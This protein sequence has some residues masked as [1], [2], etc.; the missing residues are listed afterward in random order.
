MKKQCN[1]IL[2]LLLT[3]V[4]LLTVLPISAIAS[5]WLEVEGETNK[6]GN[7]TVSDITVTLDAKAL[8]QYL[9]DRDLSG[10]VAGI[11]IDGV[12]NIVSADELFAI[13]PVEDFRA[14]IDAIESDIDPQDYLQ[15]IDVDA[16][17]KTVD[18]DKLAELMLNLSEPESYVSDFDALAAHIDLVRFETALDYVD[19]EKLERD[20]PNDLQALFG[21]TS[22]YAE[23][24]MQAGGLQALIATINANPDNADKQMS[25]AHILDTYIKSGKFVDMI[26]ALDPAGILHAILADGTFNDVFS[27]VSLVRDIGLSELVKLVDLKPFLT[28][29]Y[30]SGALKELAKEVATS[31]TPSKYV[32][33]MNQILN[34][35]HENVEEIKINGV[36][37]T[38]K[39]NGVLK[40]NIERLLE[41]LQTAI[42]TLEELAALNSKVLI[43]NVS[44]SITYCSDATGNVAKTKTINAKLALNGGIDE[45]RAVA[46]KLQSLLGKFVT[47]N[48]NG[49]DITVQ[50]VLPAKFATAIRVV[51]EELGE[52][53]TNTDLLALRDELLQLYDAN[54]SDTANFVTNLTLDQIVALLEKIDSEKFEKAYN[55]VMRQQYVQIA[56]DYIESYT[57]K[58][59]SSVELDDIIRKMDDLP[60][61]PT[62]EQIARKVESITGYDLVSKLPQR[63][64]GAWGRV[65]GDRI[66]DIFSKLAA[67]AGVDVDIQQILENA[68]AAADPVQ[69]LYDTFTNAVE[70]SGSV[71]SAAQK[72]LGNLADLL[73]SSGVGSR[74]DSIHLDDLYQGEG[75]FGGKRTIT[76]NP[77]ALVERLINKAVN[78]LDSRTD[79]DLSMLDRV[80]TAVLSMISDADMS[81]TIDATIKVTGLYQASFHD[82]NGDLIDQY[83]LPAGIDLKDLIDYTPVDP[84]KQFN[85]WKANNATYTTMPKADMVFYPDLGDNTVVVSVYSPDAISSIDIPV[86]S[87]ILLSGASLADKAD[88]LLALVKSTD[89]DWHE[90]CTVV[91]Y[92][93]ENGQ[94]V[95]VWDL[96]TPITADMSLTWEIIPVTYTVTVVDPDTMQIVGTL[97]VN[98]GALLS[99][100]DLN[101]IIA[102]IVDKDVSW[103]LVD[104]NGSIADTAYDFTAPVKAALTLTW[105]ILPDTYT[106]TVVNPL[107]VTDVKGS[108]TVIRGETVQSILSDMDAL[109]NA[110]GTK[111]PAW[112]TVENGAWGQSSKYELDAAVNADLTLTWKYYNV[113]IFNYQDTD[114]DA[115]VTF[116]ELGRDETLDRDFL[117]AQAGIP[118]GKTPAWYNVTI[119]G[120]GLCVFGADDK[121]ASSAFGATVDWDLSLTWKYYTVSVYQNGRLDEAVLEL[122]DGDILTAEM[123]DAIYV[124]AGEKA[125]DWYA[126]DAADGYLLNKANRYTFGSA[127]DWDI[128][129]APKYYTV[130]IYNN[131]TD[132]QA[133]DTF[134]LGRGETMQSFLDTL[135][136][137][138]GAD[139]ASGM[140]PAWYEYAAGNRTTLYDL[141][142]TVVWDLD[143]TWHY[144]VVT[145]EIW[146]STGDGNYTHYTELADDGHTYVVGYQSLISALLGQISG[147]YEIY[148]DYLLTQEGTEW[149]GILYQKFHNVWKDTAGTQLDVT[150][151]ILDDLTI[152]VYIEPDQT[153]AGLTVD[154]A[155]VNQDFTYS[156]TGKIIEA[157]WSDAAWKEVMSLSMNAQFVESCMNA[158][159]GVAFKS[160]D[161]TYAIKLDAALIKALW[162]NKLQGSTTTDVVL[163]YQEQD[164]SAWAS[165]TD[166]AWTPNAGSGAIGFTFD[167]LFDNV[168]DGSFFGDGRVEIT[169]P[170]TGANLGEADDVKT[171]LYID[172]VESDLASM[173]D[174]TITFTT[175]HF[176]DFMLVNKYR[177][178]YGDAAWSSTLLGIYPTGLMDLSGRP[179][180][181]TDR[182]TAGYYAEGEA[183]TYADYV[184]LGDFANGMDYIDVVVAGTN[185]SYNTAGKTMPANAVVL[186]YIV[187]T[188]VYYV[189]YYTHSG[190][191]YTC[192]G[193]TPYTAFDATLLTSS[194]I[195]AAY[196]DAKGEDGIWSGMATDWSLSAPK[197]LYLFRTEAGEVEAP[198]TLTFNWFEGDKSFTITMTRE[199]WLTSGLAQLGALIKVELSNLGLDAGANATVK[200]IF[201][202]ETV[203]SGKDLAAYTTE[204]WI[205]VLGTAN[206][207]F[208]AELARREHSVYTDGNVTGLIPE[209]AEG[210]ETVKFGVIDKLGMDIAK[211]ELVIGGNV[212]T[213]PLTA[214]DGIY[215]F[216][217][218]DADVKILVTY[219]VTTFNY[220][221]VDKNTHSDIP[222][223]TEIR[224]TVEI[225]GNKW[226]DASALDALITASGI[227]G[228]TLISAEANEQGNLVLT[229]AFNLTQD[230][231]DLSAL[232]AAAKALINDLEYQL[233]YVVNGKYYASEA[234]ALAACPEGVR[235]VWERG[236]YENMYVAS[237]EKAEDS[238]LG[239]LILLIVILVLLIII[240]VI[241]I[242]YTLYICGKLP[243]NGFLKFIT[244]I[245]SAF[246]AVCA[247]VAAAGL[248]IA[249]FFGYEE[250]DL[251]EEEAYLAPAEAPVA[252]D[253]VDL[254]AEAETATEEMTSDVTEGEVA[255][256][257]EEPV[258]ESPAVSVDAT[259]AISV[260]VEDVM[261]EMVSDIVSKAESGELDTAAMA[262]VE[263]EAV[264][265]AVTEA[266]E[267]TIEVAVED[268]AEAADDAVEGDASEE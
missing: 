35:V 216:E 119:D 7:E 14:I 52:D 214:V 226:V 245:V 224:F 71:Y 6:N 30:N 76:V 132:A 212:D 101:A 255:E 87:Y 175:E 19:F 220:I 24:V 126:V 207:A 228:M 33:C 195:L 83:F 105:K 104:A 158:G 82:E 197:N 180:M 60:T 116:F 153:S 233:V 203:I 191:G 16:F 28:E 138:A 210:G 102:T 4:M 78:V 185:E 36:I 22:D 49:N 21:G 242:L 38:E 157:I 260:T 50:V 90:G 124:A 156:A 159:Y 148:N 23:A 99:E 70:N 114:G 29:L 32:A 120:N 186:Q 51:L 13:I 174:S 248:A 12:R 26:R 84:T 80:K 172:G 42:P 39:Q 150:A 230:G 166:W 200:W 53:E 162:E 133:G 61:I 227:K 267:D 62:F 219:K 46:T 94:K 118:D 234:D 223:G 254:A 237:F 215:S 130:T 45:I 205:L 152:R 79:R 229:Y 204:D 54:L 170:F 121:L 243:P 258:E 146:G 161:G 57:G 167:F 165:K 144:P 213:V 107:D 10:L 183:L 178:S 244:N 194:S 15:Y 187:S 249:R 142:A 136:T 188:D 181:S 128:T 8:L 96:S 72:K 241:A 246:F 122:N 238:S 5:N 3:M 2:A 257:A 67:K 169:M 85:G 202:D 127:L 65:E 196:P 37:I 261:D 266:V 193:V 141:N 137:L 18:L 222:Y 198:I 143:L 171:F 92:T 199:E 95:A 91:W 231:V 236:V 41:S 68:A 164:A 149:M 58:D 66:A 74:L 173:T 189:Y 44:F 139:A 31:I 27:V 69:Y 100:A 221:G 17:L 98:H 103:H 113:S 125:P 112:Y 177:L 131:A 75:V 253:E 34:S 77:K 110:N 225:P 163:K 182:I 218:P 93:V 251:M 208:R 59:L 239:T 109:A 89:A 11:S 176:S 73:L 232:D 154:G 106:V 140:I 179:I 97:S 108:F 211:V 262:T 201:A 217:M 259:D 25:Y 265:A 56:L 247:A 235:I 240:L 155:T 43:D 135:Y 20:Y 184:F 47:Y 123:L 129:L 63:V 147:T 168:A 88:E 263:D 250:S 40:L 252:S 264:E 9:K 1:R 55:K 86:G 206:A 64:E 48:Y 81:V 117:E 145:V 192:V 190:S 209:R 256:A 160:N 115:F 268:A 134:L 111:T 151:L